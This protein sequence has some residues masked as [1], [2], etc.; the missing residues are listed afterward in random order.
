MRGST[1][2]NRY[3]DRVRECVHARAR[4]LLRPPA[5]PPANPLPSPGPCAGSPP[6]AADL[7]NEVLQLPGCPDW[8][9]TF[10]EMALSA[11]NLKDSTAVL[12]MDT[13]PH[14]G[15]HLVTQLCCC[16]L[17]VLI[18]LSMSLDPTRNV[19]YVFSLYVVELYFE[20]SGMIPLLPSYVSVAVVMFDRLR[21]PC[22]MQRN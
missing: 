7:R 10:Q 4:A 3:E 8:L 9:S 21:H 20:L 19:I 17:E 13:R 6:A 18:M 22:A 5:P 16:L 15:Y 11:I 14:R 12:R 2:Q 1:S